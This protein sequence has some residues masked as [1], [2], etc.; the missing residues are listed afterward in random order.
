MSNS[1][2]SAF[3]AASASLLLATTSVSLAGPD[4]D[5]DLTEDAGKTLATA[6][7]ITTGGNINTIAGTLGNY[8]LTGQADGQDLYLVYVDSP[9]LFRVSTVGI[10][11]GSAGFD[12]SLFAFAV[13]TSGGDAKARALLGNTSAFVGTN[14]A[15][16]VQAT[17]DG[18]NIKLEVPG[19]YLIG[20]ALNGTYPIN[21]MFESIFGDNLSTPGLVVGPSSAVSGELSDWGGAGGPGGSYVLSV[22]G[23]S[24]TLVPAPGAVALLGLA[25][26]RLRRR[27]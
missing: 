24:G 12:A 15:R 4:W 14:D 8:P 11:G 26:L 10:D 16:L 27:R 19:F 23:I 3:V 5:L 2:R 9:L 20:I 13:D 6:Q 21:S 18:S 17:N 22:Q 7:A 25:G 1:F